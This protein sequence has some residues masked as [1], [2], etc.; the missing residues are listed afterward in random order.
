MVITDVFLESRAKLK[1]LFINGKEVAVTEEWGGGDMCSCD[2]K[3]RDV[4]SKF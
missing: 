3:I 2:N 1:H 4:F